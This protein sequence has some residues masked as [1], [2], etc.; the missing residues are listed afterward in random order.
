M[1]RSMLLSTATL[2]FAI[3]ALPLASAAD[4][5]GPR[6]GIE[7]ARKGGIYVD[8]ASE[9][10]MAKAATGSCPNDP[11]QAKCPKA[12]AVVRVYPDADGRYELVP[13]ATASRHAHAAAAPWCS[14]GFSDVY[15]AAGYA[16][17]DT[18]NE[19]Y[20]K[21]RRMEIYGT[22]YKL[23]NGRWYT[24]VTRS[25][26]KNFDPTSTGK[27]AAHPRWQC[28]PNSPYRSWQLEA[29]AYTYSQGVWYAA[30]GYGFGDLWC[31]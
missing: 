28:V 7:K 5:A 25:Q 30:G 15:K 1:V 29:S 24:M 8:P 17:G 14:F 31:G 10:L 2:A 20:T 11:T 12:Q 26:V 27:V 4:P 3:V 16:Q 9:E 22:L 19:C 23:Y 6:D 21:V 13:P 18:S